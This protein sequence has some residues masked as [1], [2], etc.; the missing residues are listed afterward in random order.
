MD[1]NLKNTSFGIIGPKSY[2][3]TEENRQFI[4]DTIKIA[5]LSLLDHDSDYHAITIDKL[6]KD[7]DKVQEILER[8]N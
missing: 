7:L 6:Y 3:L 5:R 8:G 4:I 2:S 1:E